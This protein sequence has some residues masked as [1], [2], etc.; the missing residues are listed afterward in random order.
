V[1]GLGV[2]IRGAIIRLMFDFLFF[3]LIIS[4]AYFS[5]LLL[6]INIIPDFPSEFELKR[7]AREG[8]GLAKKQAWVKRHSSEVKITLSLLFLTSEG[9]FIVLLS[10]RLNQAWSA[11][12]ISVFS[13]V[14]M[15]FFI[16]RD[17]APRM[18]GYWEKLLIKKMP[19]LINM[20]KMILKPIYGKSYNDSEKAKSFYSEEEFIYRFGI[21]SEVLSDDTRKKIERSLKTS[22]TKAK[23]IMLDVKLAPRVDVNLDLTPV[24][25][26]E[27]HKKGYDMAL[28]FSGSKDNFLGILYLSGSEAVNQ[29]NSPTSIKVGDKM[30]QGLQYVTEDTKLNELISG[31]LQAG[32]NA[33]LVTG[34]GGQ[35]S[36]VITARKLLA[37]I[38]GS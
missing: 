14:V 29:L 30:E 28:A 27:L 5:A 32:Q 20:F 22:E 35:V 18:F 11:V 17:I 38:S 4:L 9:L 8:D 26:D 10:S 25:Y 33:V 6:N 3:S 34:A 21:D 37:W 16:V 12:L 7:K 15:R 19:E 13:F 36:G 31:F 23:D 24:I 1:S 2:F